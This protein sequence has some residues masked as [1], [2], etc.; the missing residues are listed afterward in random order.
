MGVGR[1]VDL[2]AQELDFGRLK[3][4]DASLLQTQSKF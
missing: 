2:K 1:E 3:M 4:G